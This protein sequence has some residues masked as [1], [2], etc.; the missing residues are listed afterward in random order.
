MFLERSYV[1]FTGIR[2]I[3]YRNVWTDHFNE[4]RRSDV[5]PKESGGNTD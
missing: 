5:D 4:R 2:T 1:D 3:Y